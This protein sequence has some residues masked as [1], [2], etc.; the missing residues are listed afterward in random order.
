MMPETIDG[1]D[2]GVDQDVGQVG[3][4]D[5]AL[6]EVADD[7]RIDAGDDAGLGRGEDARQDAADD[8]ERRQE[9]GPGRAHGVPQ[10]AQVEAAGDLAQLR[11]VRMIGVEL[12]W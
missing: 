11:I 6:D 4:P 5:L 7:E 3:Q 12:D 8:D 10:G 9:P 1:G 2:R